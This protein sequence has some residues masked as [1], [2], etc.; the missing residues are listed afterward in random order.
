MARDPSPTRLVMLMK[1]GTSVLVFLELVVLLACV[2][3]RL[4]PMR[5]WA[6]RRRLRLELLVPDPSTSRQIPA[7]GPRVLLAPRQ[8][9][10][11]TK[12]STMLL[13]LRVVLAPPAQLVALRPGISLLVRSLVSLVQALHRLAPAHRG[14][15]PTIRL[16]TN[17]QPPHL[18]VPEAGAEET[19]SGVTRLDSAHKLASGV[20]S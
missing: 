16:L 5:I 3:P 11:P 17:V 2:E 8:A 10:R 6:V 15:H 20:K 14:P 12:S 18:Q 19:V 7:L 13:D 4:L 9:R 1:L